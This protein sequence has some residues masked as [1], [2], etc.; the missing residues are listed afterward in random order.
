MGNSVDTEHGSVLESL[1][2]AIRSMQLLGF[3]GGRLYA[4]ALAISTLLSVGVLNIL[5]QTYTARVILTSAT[6]DPLS[7]VTEMSSGLAG[8]A[9]LSLGRENPDFTEFIALLDSETVAQSIAKDPYL[10]HNLFR[11]QWDAKT[12]SWRQASL[13]KT[14]FY[15]LQS[16]LTGRRVSFLASPYQI[17]KAITERL[18][19][20]KRGQDNIWT[21]SFSDKNKVFAKKLLSAVISSANDI[22]LKRVARRS[23]VYT[24]F[25]EK[26]LQASKNVY[27]RDALASIAVKV[28]ERKI[29]ALSKQ[30][31]PARIVSG[32]TAPDSPNNPS[33]IKTFLLFLVGGQLFAFGYRFLQSQSRLK[34]G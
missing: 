3:R 4:Y 11:A 17:H 16:L 34:R 6:P 2:A 20:T 13:V 19:I 30:G 15:D 10:V 9:G 7:N 33:V 1:H 25:L 23:A 21:V 31:V 12:H 18:D 22:I 27:T 5:P 29:L 8:L 24:K 32:P 14:L 28:E 26:Q